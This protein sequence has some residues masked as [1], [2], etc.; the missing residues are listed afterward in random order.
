MNLLRKLAVWYVLIA[1]VFFFGML[2][3]HYQWF[4]YSWG[5]NIVNFY[6]GYGGEDTNVIE[7]LLSDYGGVPRRFI[8]SY[9]PSNRSAMTEV[10]V[11]GLQARRAQPLVM[12]SDDAP[13]GYRILFGAF[14]FEE[15]LWGALL[16][17][18]DGKPVHAW[19]L[20]T[21]DLPFNTE[22]AFRKN[23]YGVDVLQDGSIIFLMQETGG[24][25]VKVDY[26]G[27]KQW[28][29]DGLFHHT[30]TPTED[31]KFW[32][33]EGLQTDFDHVFAL[34]NIADGKLVKKIDMKEVRKA[35]PDL[36]IFDLQREPDVLNRVH[37]NDVEPLPAKLAAD[38]PQFKQ[39]DLLISYRTINL[40][41]IL[42]PESLKIKWWR[43]GPWDRQHDGDW[44]P[45]GY[46][47]VY[48]NNTRG[49]G[50]Y[51][52][53]VSINPATYETDV[54][55]KGREH[56]FYSAYNGMHEV[57]SAGTVLVTSSRQGRIFEVSREG[58]VVFDFINQFDAAAG[59]ALH[60][61]N[62][63]FLGPDFF[64]FEKL[65]ACGNP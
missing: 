61:S 4:P 9:S 52:N 29:I 58:K 22:P 35:N 8:V 36:H 31:G 42:D 2:V 28:S 16:L 27:R 37:G 47:S 51:S 49:L 18:P 32:S 10:K 15:T 41:F 60:V 55:V 1:A 12:L 50:E 39:G 46:I 65:P 19:R 45:G 26:C 38:F 25:I 43:I 34:F 24:G 14:D 63:R 20:S 57:T 30:V 6:R 64:D 56:N 53:I 44:N 48:S 13:Y 11:P 40:L 17:D 21:D 33:I 23:M 3:G 5:A 54:L 7:K 59:E 62:A